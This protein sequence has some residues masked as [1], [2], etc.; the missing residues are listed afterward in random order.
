MLVKIQQKNLENL[1][2]YV[3]GYSVI[4]FVLKGEEGPSKCKR[5]QTRRRRIMS[6][7]M[8]AYNFC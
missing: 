1:T 8:F 3:R 4:N 6:L 7:R 2:Y 5:M